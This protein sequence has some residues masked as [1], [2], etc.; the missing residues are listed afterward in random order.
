MVKPFANMGPTAAAGGGVPSAQASTLNSSGAPSGLA[1]P[2]IQPH[3]PAGTPGG[4]VTPPERYS[5]GA[6]P[7]GGRAGAATQRVATVGNRSTMIS[8]S[9]TPV[10]RSARPSAGT[11]PTQGLAV[12]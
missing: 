4:M 1:S 10:S 3:H 2:Q 8:G 12:S 9:S 5:Y 11:F 6:Q 7:Y